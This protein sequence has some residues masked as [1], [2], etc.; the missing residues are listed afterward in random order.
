MYAQRPRQPIVGFTT[1]SLD[2]SYW[3]VFGKRF[4]FARCGTGQNWSGTLCGYSL[5]KRLTSGDDPIPMM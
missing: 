5:L 3:V 2:S 4:A 1:L